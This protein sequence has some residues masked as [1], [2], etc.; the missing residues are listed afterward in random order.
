VST[1]SGGGIADET[2]DELLDP[3][4]EERIRSELGGAGPM[5]Q[6]VW[7]RISGA[8]TAE[9][10]ARTTEVA[11]PVSLASATPR[12]I[13]ALADR[14]RRRRTPLLAG[15]AAAAAGVI[16]VAVIAPRLSTG[17]AIVASDAPASA[18]AGGAQPVAEPAAGVPS[19]GNPMAAA[20]AEASDPLAKM[21]AP[22][23]L[24]A[25][26][27]PDGAAAATP[28]LATTRSRDVGAFA[29]RQVVRSGTDYS[30]ESLDRDVMALVDT[31]GAS[32]T[33]LM[34]S[35]QEEADPTEGDT[36]FTATP[37]GLAGCVVALTRS[38][39]AQALVIDRA[40]FGGAD[41]GIVVVPVG[42]GAVD[43]AVPF[44]RVDVWVVGPDCG[45]QSPSI[46]WFGTLEMP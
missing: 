4:I 18:A 44:D 27:P 22:P 11:A 9:A 40:T 29:A 23:A 33:R 17:D 16:A 46:Q 24:S 19:A 45:P 6:A 38:S 28:S 35:V 36:G 2:D 26:A 37:E 20:E 42:T 39:G 25:D 3:A 21:A 30:E 1:D 8:L 14:P 43:H 41:V 5:P 15:L 12:G 32:R 7:L 31:I 34:S 10:S 13:V